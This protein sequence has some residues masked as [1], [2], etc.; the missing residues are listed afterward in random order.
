M[1]DTFGESVSLTIAG[2]SH[3]KGIIAILSGMA[4][5]VPVKEDYIAEELAKRRPSGV[6]STGRQE[7]DKFEILSGVFEGFST[8]TPITIFIPNSDIHSNDYSELKHTVRPGHADLTAEVKYHGFQDHRGGGHF[9][10]RV[11]AG[12]VAAGAICRKA[13][14]DIGV[15]I[16][17]HVAECGGVADRP[18]ESLPVDIATLY[19]RE[20][21]PVL[22]E[23][24]GVE[25][26]KAIFAAKSDLDSVGGI[27]ETAVCWFPVGVGEPYFESVESKLSQILFSIPAVKGVEF[28]EGFGFAKLRGSEANDSFQYDENGILHAETN[29]NGGINGGI[30]NG[31]PIVFRCVIKPTPPIG[32]E[33]D[34]VDFE[35]GE[36][37]KISIAGR[38]DPCIVH[39]A[40]AVIN[41]ATS[42]AL[43]D[44]LAQRFGTDVF[45]E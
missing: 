20:G 33:Q 44:L 19:E 35:K 21:F 39:R 29:H 41:A 36:N 13:L 12:I 2:E 9:S 26:Q 37:K 17:T 15:R 43:C 4:P 27:A 24:R 6:I 32:R 1:K 42:I 8:G 38:H 16:G 25:M 7:Q 28:G 22:D 34:T 11:T 31:E 3:G 40:C 23:E 30:T 5:G 18:F 45:G 14:W 10:G